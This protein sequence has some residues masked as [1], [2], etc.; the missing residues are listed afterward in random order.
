MPIKQTVRYNRDGM[1]ASPIADEI[2]VQ[3]LRMAHERVL[4]RYTIGGTSF[5]TAEDVLAEA[6]LLLEFFK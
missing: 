1:V 3:V 4:S 5:P 2:S 6:K